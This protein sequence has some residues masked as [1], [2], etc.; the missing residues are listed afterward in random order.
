MSVYP[1]NPQSARTALRTLTVSD[2]HANEA[3]ERAHPNSS[4]AVGETRPGG[5]GRF[6]V[7]AICASMSGSYQ[8]LPARAPPADRSPPRQVASTSATDGSPATYIVVAVV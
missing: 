1:R 2:S 7:G 4:A 5:T 8:W 3:A 6:A